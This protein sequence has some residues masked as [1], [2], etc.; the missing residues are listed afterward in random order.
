MIDFNPLTPEYRQNP[1]P[2][3]HALRA[4]DPVHWSAGGYCWV[5]TRYDH[6]KGFLADPRCGIGLDILAAQP[7]LAPVMAE[8]YNQIIRTQMLSSDPPAH[9]RL[10]GIASRTFTAAAVNELK[11]KIQKRVDDLFAAHAGTRTMDFITDFAYPLPFAVICDIMG[12][13]D[14]ERFPLEKFTHDLMRTTDPTPMT[15]QCTHEANHAAIGFR[16]YFL[17]LVPRAKAGSLFAHMAEALNEGQ[18]DAEELVANSILIFCAGH[19]TVVNLFGNGLLALLRHPDQ[20]ALLR[21]DPSLTKNAV[22]ELLRY[23]ASVQ[24]A[25]RLAFE[26][27]ELGGKWIQKG[28]YVLCMLGA[29]NRDPDMYPDPDRV[30]ITRPNIRPLSFGGGIHYCLGAGLARVE[31]EVVFSTISQRMPEMHITVD[32]PPFHRNTF[33]RGLSSLPIAW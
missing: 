32:N 15:D 9:P 3:L 2:H 28:A 10:R 24:I 4:V 22:E 20:V 7:A 13:P 18:M 14:E 6:I 17:D 31:G 33:V 26:D 12:I 11:G 16:D 30:D 1:Y 8:P 5:L 29:G 21:Q 23:D 25:R 27:L 19:D